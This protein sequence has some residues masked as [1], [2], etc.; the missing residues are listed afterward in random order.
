MSVK[1]IPSIIRDIYSLVS[2]LEE[3]FPTRKFTPDGHLVGSIG[4]VLVAHHY[5][6]KLFPASSPD[7]DALAPNGANVQIKATQGNSIGMRSESEHLIV[8]KILPRGDITEI[9]NGPGGLAWEKGGKMQKNGQRP[10]SLSKLIEL[11]KSVA[12][13]QCLPRINSNA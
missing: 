11:Q 8:I 13:N 6:L 7:H 10:I 12:Q 1:E 3:L 5:G 2:R 4:E 9:Y